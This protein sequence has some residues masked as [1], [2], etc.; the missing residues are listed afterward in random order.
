MAPYCERCWQTFDN[1]QILNAH[2][3]VDATEICQVKPGHPPDGLTPEMER[4]LRSRKKAHRDQTDEDRWR[5]MYRLL[6]PNEDVPSPCKLLP[7][8]NEVMA[9][10]NQI[11]SQC[12][13]ELPYRLILGTSQT[14]KSMHAGSCH[15]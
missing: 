7:Q 1:Q 6:F 10:N 15:V 3:T 2:I 13:T 4:K 5:D 8:S 14:M 9:L 11:L 12:K